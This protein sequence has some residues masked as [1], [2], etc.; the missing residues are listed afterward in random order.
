MDYK[1]EENSLFNNIGFE[2]TYD[3]DRRKFSPIQHYFFVDKKWPLPS[4]QIALSLAIG[5]LWESAKKYTGVLAA[6]SD[7][8]NLQFI[9]RPNIEF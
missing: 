9:L 8:N 6:G 4:R 3:M 1:P 7:K 5:F 2:Y